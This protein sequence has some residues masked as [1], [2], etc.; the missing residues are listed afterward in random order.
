MTTDFFILLGGVGM[1][2]LGMDVMTGALREAAGRN[3]RALLARFTTTP[4]RGTV[5]GAAATAVIQSS[6]A[7]TVM[8]VG[9]VG[10]GLMTLGQALGII[11]GANVGT[12]ATGWLVSLLGFKLHLGRLAL[13]L[14]LPASLALLLGRGALARGGRAVAGLCLLLIGLDMMQAGMGDAAALITA[15]RLPGADAA[16]LLALA[17][18]GLAVTVLIQSSSAGVALA[19]VMLQGGTIALPQAAALVAG[20]NVGT[21]FTGLL[22]SLGGSRA[23]RQT[24]VA[25]LV[26]HLAIAAMALPFV[27][28]GADALLWLGEASDPLTALLL[29]HTGF[30]LVGAAVF[31]PFTARYARLIARLVPERAADRLIVLDRALLSEPAAALLAAQAAVANISRRMFLALAAGLRE[32]PDY[33]PLSALDPVVGSALDELEA[34]LADIRLPDDRPQEQESYSA[35]LHSADH[36]RRL[37]SRS[38]QKARIQ[39]LL[40]DRVLRR[41]ALATGAALGRAGASEPGAMGPERLARLHALVERRTRRY[42]RGLLLGAQARHTAVSSVFAHTDAMRWL[43]RVLHHG[44]RIGHYDSLAGRHLRLAP[45]PEQAGA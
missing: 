1:F 14:L 11:Y 40:E 36:L 26:F 41:P 18:I 3:L 33:R 45:P 43:D 31:L 5:T 12:T 24:A 37:L 6:S 27:A 10:A 30:N 38:A 39:T 42:R 28:L 21:T 17:G 7:T 15:Q 23:M 9:F 35:L 32:P 29:F 8:T 19:L 13:A 20:M 34:F 44:E 25:N 22:A 4:L 2:L 16:G